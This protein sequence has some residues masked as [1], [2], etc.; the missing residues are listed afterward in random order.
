LNFEVFLVEGTTF[1]VVGSVLDD[2][3]LEGL[4]VD[5]SGAF[6]ARASVRADGTFDFYII[7]PESNWGMVTGTVTD[8]QNGMS[9]PYEDTVD[10]T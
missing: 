6:D 4:Y 9:L 8:L 2:G 7:V 10:V 5:F 3:A 1:W